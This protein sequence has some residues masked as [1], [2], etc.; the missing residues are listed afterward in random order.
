VA[1]GAN[2]R[3][4]DTREGGTVNEIKAIETSYKGY[5]FRSRIEARWAIF[6]DALGVAWEYEHQG[7]DLGHFGHYLPDFWL[8]DWDVYL[9]IKP[10]LPK[11]E[12][13]YKIM[14]LGQYGEN[15]AKCPADEFGVHM[16][17]GNPWPEEYW[18][19]SH[20]QGVHAAPFPTA[21]WCVCS[22]CGQ[23]GVFVR[24]EGLTLWSL[25]APPCDCREELASFR[26]SDFLMAAFR[27]ARSARFEHGETPDPRRYAR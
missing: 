6:L 1:A 10:V 23:P 26:S 7:Y 16:L 4:D 13:R 25:M 19:F 11:P 12:E 14:A 5:R 8:T 24:L 9:E 22:S 2:A 17:I 21:E 3:H 15:E 27:A 18:F 20:I